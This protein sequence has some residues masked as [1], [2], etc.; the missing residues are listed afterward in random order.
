MSL[1]WELRM[2]DFIVASVPCCELSQGTL[3]MRIGCVEEMST[4][5]DQASEV[6]TVVGLLRHC[7]SVLAA[8][9]RGFV[10]I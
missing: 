9:S 2:H 4:V 1:L 5:A 3:D 10:V 7:Q 6:Q 8:W